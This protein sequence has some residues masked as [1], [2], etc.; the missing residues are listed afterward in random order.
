MSRQ[1]ALGKGAPAAAVVAAA[2]YAA[3]EQSLAAL[4]FRAAGRA[5]IRETWRRPGSRVLVTAADDVHI[6]Q[7][8]DRSG[9][10]QSHLKDVVGSHDLAHLRA[11]EPSPG[12][13]VNTLVYAVAS[14]F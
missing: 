7:E 14:W 1:E 11:K 13:G 8:E 10:D 9:S 12:V 4:Q 2:A 3:V 6:G 5:V